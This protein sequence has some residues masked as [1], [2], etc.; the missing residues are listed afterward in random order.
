MAWEIWS[1]THPERSYG[2]MGFFCNTTDHSFGPVFMTDSDF[3][4]GEFYTMWEK[5]GFKDP[6]RD[7]DNI[8]N[9]T[10]RI[11]NL[12][13]YDDNIIATM[14]VIR[15]DKVNAPVV[16]FEKTEKTYY[17]N[18]GFSPFD[19]T[20]E[21]LSEDDFHSVESLMEDCNGDMKTMVLTEEDTKAKIEGYSGFTVSMEW[22]VLD[23]Y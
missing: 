8:S 14:K 20:L 2:Q 16:I 7:D 22:E 23:S 17:D 15:S 13:G 12:M 11:L 18:L 1:D 3:D 5:A 19:K 21:A 4:K 6:R 9:H 10:R